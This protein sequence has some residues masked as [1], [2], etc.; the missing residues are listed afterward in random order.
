M[1]REKVK[2]NICLLL[3]IYTIIFGNLIYKRKNEDIIYNDNYCCEDQLFATFYGKNIYIVNDKSLT[4][5]LSS[6]DDIYILDERKIENPNM[7]VCDSYKVINIY[8]MQKII[9]MIKEY[10]KLSPTEWNRSDHAMLIE[11]VAHN[12]GYYFNIQ[13]NRTQ[14]VDFDNDEEQK[15]NVFILK[16]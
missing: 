1:K 3:S 5:N 13:R 6:F 7:R 11:W 10:D 9:E 12:I 14:S 4:E 16:K 2:K 8:E 15:Y